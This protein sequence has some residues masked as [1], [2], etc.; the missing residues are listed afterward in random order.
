MTKILII[1]DDSQ[2]KVLYRGKFTDEGFR[3]ILATTGEEGLSKAKTEHPNLIL[4]DIMLPGGINGFDVLEELK[5]NEDLKKIPVVVLTSLDNEEKVAKEIGA[6]D[7]II[8]AHTDPKDI[9]DI[10]NKHLR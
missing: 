2:L 5:R 10:V 8:K 7:Y 3:V 1:E 9:V 4:L 6:I